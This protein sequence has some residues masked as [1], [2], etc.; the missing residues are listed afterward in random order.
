VVAVFTDK[1]IETLARDEHK[2][3]IIFL[4][5]GERMNIG[6]DFDGVLNTND[7]LAMLVLEDN[8]AYQLGYVVCNQE[9]K[10]PKYRYG[11][12]DIDNQ[13]YHTK[14]HNYINDEKFFHEMRMM[15]NAAPIIVALND[16]G[17]KTFLVTARGCDSNWGFDKSVRSYIYETI[18]RFGLM[19]AGLII[20]SLHSFSDPSIKKIDKIAQC[21]NLKID[22]LV[23]DDLENIKH[24]SE[25]GFCTIHFGEEAKSWEEVIVRIKYI[26]KLKATY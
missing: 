7:E 22:V 11:F 21:R 9:A 20:D 25:A 2:R 1:Q 16:M 4:G 6:I 17:H 8:I 13:L 18:V 26:E 14:R 15:P 24:V 19:K 10:N 3:C 23:D 5:R 12:N